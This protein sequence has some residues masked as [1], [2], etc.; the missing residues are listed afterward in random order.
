MV[1]FAAACIGLG[2]YP[3]PLYD[4]LPYPVEYVPYTVS[5]VVS[6]L[7][8]LMFAGLAFFV[9]LPQLQRTRTITLDID[10]TWRV[11][12][13]RLVDEG[14]RLLAST[15][16]MAATRRSRLA[17]R[18]GAILEHPAPHWGT[19]AMTSAVVLML[20]FYLVLFYAS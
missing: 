13:P 20:A 19:G 14:R 12:G 6:Q 1:V 2:V 15:R 4:I 18:L 10:W 9:M 5:H 7:Q 11:A 17:N 8:L 16:D 3:K